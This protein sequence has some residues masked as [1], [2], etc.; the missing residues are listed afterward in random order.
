[1]D[2]L[3]DVCCLLS[4]VCARGGGKAEGKNI[5]RLGDAGH[6]VKPN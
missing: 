4:V 1:M 5:S 6:A 3:V 2:A